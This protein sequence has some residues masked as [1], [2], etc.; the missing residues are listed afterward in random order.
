MKVAIVIYDKFDLVNLAEFNEFFKDERKFDTKIYAFKGE[1]VD[2]FGVCIKVEN[3]ASS[4]YGSDILVVCDG[5]NQSLVY[6]EIFLSW[7]KSAFD[8][9]YKIC[10]GTAKGILNAAKFDEFLHSDKFDNEFK[11]SIKKAVSI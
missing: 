3:S 7:L 9:R 1:I 8:V 10:V 4:L 6:D 11:A 5:K 2:K